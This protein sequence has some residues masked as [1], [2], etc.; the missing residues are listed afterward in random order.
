MSNFIHNRVCC[1]FTVGQAFVHVGTGK[2]T[3]RPV[4]MFAR[5]QCCI[6][7]MKF[8]LYYFI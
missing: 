4:S 8:C 3:V 7:G 1:L 5:L 6:P 2:V